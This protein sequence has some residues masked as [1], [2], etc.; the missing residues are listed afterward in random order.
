MNNFANTDILIL[1]GG[2]GE[3]LRPEIGEN[4][5]VMADING[6][7]FLSVI[8][9]HLIAQGF[10]RVVLCTGYK[11]DIVEGYYKKNPLGLDIRFSREDVPLG[12]GGGLKNAAG[13]VQS[14]P[15]FVLNG[16]SFCA[17]DFGALLKFHQS[18][19]AVGSIVLSKVENKGDF[20]TVS[21]AGDGKILAFREKVKEATSDA[22][23]AGVY[24]FDK[25]ILGLMPDKVKFS[26]EKEFF[27]QLI[28][29][30]FYG[31]VTGDNFVD[32]GTPERYHQ[33]KEILKDR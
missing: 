16:D 10:K 4:P 17:A 23:N 21:I 19:R 8:L 12:T 1:C 32:I 18:R 5:K 24:C 31:M 11:A 33:A 6:R 13:F 27:P 15:F 30:E 22:V 29:S 28:G 2:L 20:G 7:P 26:L 3:R 25:K 9:N 14:S